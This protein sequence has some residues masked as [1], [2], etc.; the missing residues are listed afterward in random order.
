M[1]DLGVEPCATTYGS[2]RSR[3]SETRPPTRSLDERWMRAGRITLVAALRFA[4]PLAAHQHAASAH[5]ATP[6]C[7]TKL[8]ERA[9]TPIR[10]PAAR[11]SNHPTR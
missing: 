10:C 8:A 1:G 6:R 9:A 5:P 11:A 4:S 2:S 3:S 7:R